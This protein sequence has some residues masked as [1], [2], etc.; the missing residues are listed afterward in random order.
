MRSEIEIITSANNEYITPLKVM[1]HSLGNSLHPDQHAT[2]RVLTFG[3]DANNEERLVSGLSHLPLSVQ[4]VKIDSVFLEGLKISG[5]VSG[6][7]YLRLLS[8]RVFPHLSKALYLDADILI[9]H[10]IHELYANSIDG[11]HL[12]AVPHVSRL[13]A[14]FGAE[15]GVPSFHLLGIPPTTRTFN[16]GVMLLNLRLWRETGTTERVLRYLR[17]YKEHVLWWDQDGLNAVLHNSW[18]ALPP[19]WNVMTSHFANFRSWEDS[20]LDE[21]TFRAVLE[22]PAIVHFSYVPKPWQPEYDGPFGVLWRETCKEITQNM[23]DVAS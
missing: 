7:T 8:P 15:R 4:I 2:V 20:M 14:F 19:K 5:H 23:R 10:S 18:R 6:E 12:L 17:D 22:D 1:L 3:I 16:A 9:R 13:S 21:A 11:A